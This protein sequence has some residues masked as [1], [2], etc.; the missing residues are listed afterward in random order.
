MRQLGHIRQGVQVFLKL[1]FWNKKQ[2]NSM[3]RS[4]IGGIE[5]DSAFRTAKNKNHI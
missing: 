3:N 1:S 5:D 4:G 2:T